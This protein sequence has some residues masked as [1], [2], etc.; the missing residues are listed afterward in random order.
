MSHTKLR[1]VSIE[2]FAMLNDLSS[3][4]LSFNF[5]AHITPNGFSN[6]S[7]RLEHIDL[8]N[9]ELVGIPISNMQK[10]ARR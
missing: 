5:L 3:L 1:S 10:I 9:N 7:V 4:N 6:I 2:Y 8:S